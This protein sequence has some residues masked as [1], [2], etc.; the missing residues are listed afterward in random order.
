[1]SIQWIEVREKAMRSRVF[2]ALLVV[3]GLHRPALGL[4]PNA[5]MQSGTQGAG[6]QTP[7]VADKNTP[8]SQQGTA[9]A[10]Q[11]PA[12]QG[13][14][15]GLT[16]KDL[17]PWIIASVAAVAAIG[18]LAFGIY[19]YCRRQADA[20]IKATVE[21]EVKKESERTEEQKRQ[22]SDR[23][24]YE[25]V[26]RQELG[27]IQMLGLPDVRNVPVRLFDTFVSL[28]ISMTWRSE[29][30][31]DPDCGDLRDESDR[32]LDPDALMK[33]AFARHHMLLIVGDPGS[34]K[35][36]LLKYYAMCCVEG[37]YER[38][39][40]GRRPLPM[41]LPLRD[42]QVDGQGPTGLAA[43]LARWAGRYALQAPAES[44]S[45][46]LTDEPTLVLLD[47]LDEISDLKR[48]RAICEWIDQNAT[49]L[50]NARFVVTS[51]WTGYRK[52]DGIELGFEHLQA[53]IRDFT[54][55]Q[56]QDFLRKWFKAAYANEP[57]PESADLARWRSQQEAVSSKRAQEII[58]FL[59]KRENT[60]VRELAGVPMLLQIIAILWKEQ[61]VRLNVRSDLYQA[62]VKYLLDFRDRR[63]GL[64]PLMS[65]NDALRVLYPVALWMQQ[66]LHT[67]EVSKVQVHEQMQPIIKTIQPDLTAEQFCDNLRD[68]AGLVADYGKDACIFR[69]KSFREYLAGMQL[70]EQ[71]KRDPKSIRQVVQHLGDDWWEETLRFFMA[72]V[73]D[74]VFDGFMDALFRSDVSKDLDPKQQSLLRILIGDARQRRIDSLVRCLNDRRLSDNKKR[75]ILDCL[76]TIGTPEALDAVRVYSEQAPRSVVT[77]K[78][79]EIIA[80]Q[81]TVPEATA[82]TPQVAD[83]IFVRK[84][85]SFRNPFELNA[86]YIL[87]PGGSFTYSVDKQ[88]HQVPDLYFAKYPVTNKRYRR[89]I[90]YLQGQEAELQQ[91]LGLEAFARQLLAFAQGPKGEGLG[92]HLDS[93]VSQWAGKLRSGYDQEKRFNGEDQPVV[94]ISWYAAKAYC[95][96]LSALEGSGSEA[97]YRLPQEIEWEWAAGHGEREYPW[98]KEKGEPNPKLANYG[99][100]MGATTPVGQYPEGATPEG[101]VDM[102]GNVWEWMEN[103]YDN[104]KDF[105]SLRGGSWNSSQVYLR[106]SSRN[107]AR[108]PG[109]YCFVGFRVVRSQS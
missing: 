65:A 24:C 3:I 21:A 100:N 63:R 69:H 35:T 99:E 12:K 104:D 5:A 47:G 2:I 54:P 91:V 19:Q 50:A 81:R 36:T 58:D 75:Y 85:A 31:F 106:C 8:G 98:P 41:Y 34:G 95:A 94:G 84:P 10:G 55:D 74:R 66:T 70:N 87:I 29:Q 13:V 57:P 38:L 90:Q 6:Q 25:A 88:V 102:A 11:Q 48:R 16:A 7:A 71:A 68:R 60:A 86:E 32:H 40:F 53:D 105:V 27:T 28:D 42:V 37:D 30:R 33:R 78:A 59:A 72:E 101:L 39:G 44:F 107:D 1:M 76:K 22:Q 67:D 14:Q 15:G 46:W 49:G 82:T 26:L 62:A 108:P 96:W 97:A 77:K 18:G 43:S 109:G 51:R 64:D 45:R 73:D 17:I 83:D 103:Y 56:Q 9:P 61:G 20:V 4:D 89:F 93:E 79:E 80:E 52:A 92:E 23:D